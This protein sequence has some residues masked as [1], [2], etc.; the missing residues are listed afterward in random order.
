MTW[1]GWRTL[2]PETSVVSSDA[3]PSRRYTAYPYGD[4]DV[5]DNRETLFP[6]GID[7]RRPA[8]ERVLGIPDGEG[9][10][11]FP[12]GALDEIGPVAAV[13]SVSRGSEIV[14]FWDRDREAAMAF[15]PE[16]DGEQLDFLTQDGQLVDVQTGSVWSVEGTAL[17]G[18]KSGAAL[19]PVAEAFVA[20]WFAWPEF[21]P[22]IQLW[23]AS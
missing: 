19:E 12:Y 14:V 17:T 18:P 7:P 10:L 9:G 23:S 1:K 3:D 4:Y 20:F 11:A 22:R 15:L 13:E 16:V 21:Y 5:L 2:H 8:K 6:A